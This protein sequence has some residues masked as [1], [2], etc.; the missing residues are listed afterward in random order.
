MP[1]R[2]ILLALLLV[3]AAGGASA[4]HSIVGQFDVSRSVTLRGTVVKLDW[5]NP[6]PYLR[7][8]VRDGERITTWALSTAP[9]AM[10]RK[11]GITRDA[12]AGTP[13]ELV[14]VTV[15]PALNGKPFGWITRITYAD[16][17]FYALAE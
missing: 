3:H 11:A 17:H 10:L 7:V 13:G 15:F 9:I 6:H 2:T 8:E 12:F 14:T 1:T 5:I 16:G 4:H